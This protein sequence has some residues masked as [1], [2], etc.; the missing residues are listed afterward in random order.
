MKVTIGTYIKDRNN[1]MLAYP[2]ITKLEALVKDYPFL[3]SPQFKAMW[4]NAKSYVKIRTLEVM[5]DEWTEAPSWLTDKV[6]RAIAERKVGNH[7]T[8]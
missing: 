4:K 1:A 7:E 6:K 3:F 8:N 2:D 5:I